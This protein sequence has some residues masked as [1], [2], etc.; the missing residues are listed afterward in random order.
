MALSKSH[1]V[2]PGPGVCGPFPARFDQVVAY[3]IDLLLAGK[4]GTLTYGQQQALKSPRSAMKRSWQLV[5]AER[6]SPPRA[7][8][9]NK[10]RLVYAKS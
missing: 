7:K 2:C 9:N 6:S 1:P 8:Q 10:V 4:I 3:S 5:M